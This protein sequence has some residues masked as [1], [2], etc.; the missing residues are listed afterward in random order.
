MG[1]VV[2]LKRF[3]KRGEREQAAKQAEA[4]RALFGRTKSERA[5]DEFLGER[6][7]RV[8]DQHRIDQQRIESGDAS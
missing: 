5:R 7:A 1:D 4:N 2:N 3:K 8:L 6:N